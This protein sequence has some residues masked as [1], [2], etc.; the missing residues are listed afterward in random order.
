MILTQIDFKED[1]I[2][3][4]SEIRAKARQQ[5]GNNIFS[6]QWL[7]ALVVCLIV[8]AISGIASSTVVIPL[9]ISGPLSFG[10]TKV[11]LK[12]ARSG[13]AIKIEDTFG[14]FTSDLGGNII[15]G[16]L[17]SVF[18]FLWSLLF[19]IP[20]I[21]KAYSYSMAF[22]IKHDNPT[23]TW[24]Q[25]IDESRKMMDGNKMRLFLLDLSFIGWIIVGMLCLGI[26]TLW[27]SP[28]M[29]AAHANF[30]EEISQK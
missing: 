14:G 24:K 11:F 28:Y 18:T 2:M 9:L 17:I 13:D 12:L 20:G 30:Y 15:L 6:N 22:Y 7:Y 26:G 29:S 19:V 21:V 16:L 3:T 10:A 5:L 8:T 27:V 4:A 25:C 23:Y 1:F